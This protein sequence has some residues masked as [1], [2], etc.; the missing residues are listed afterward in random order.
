MKKAVL[1]LLVLILA[2]LPSVSAE[3][4]LDK[5]SSS[6]YNLGDSVY[7]SGYVTQPKEVMANLNTMLTCSGK[8]EQIDAQILDLNANEKKL[9]SRYSIIP[10]S[11]LGNCTVEISLLDGEAVLE[12]KTFSGFELINTIGGKFDSPKN[13]FQLGETLAINGLFSKVDKGVIDGAAVITFNKENKK[14]FIDTSEVTKGNLK[15]SRDLSRIP[16]GNYTIDISITDNWGNRGD[17]KG[18]LKLIITSKVEISAN[19][20]KNSYNPGEKLTITGYVTSASGEKLKDVSMKFKFED[21]EV[22]KKLTGTD[23]FNVNY[24]IPANVKSGVHKVEITAKDSQGNYGFKSVEFKVN[25]VA[26]FLDFEMNN[27][28]YEP[29]QDAEFKIKLLDQANEVMEESVNVNLLNPKGE[30]AS[31][32]TVKAGAADTIK[33]PD[34]AEPGVWKLSASGFGLTKETS[35]VVKEYTKL[36]ASIKEDSLIVKNQGNIPFKGDFQ[37]NGD[38]VSKSKELNIDVGKEK[39]VDLSKL[40]PEGSY[41]ISTPQTDQVFDNVLIDRKS[42]FGGLDSM[43]SGA[44]TSLNN[45]KKRGILFILAIIIL[46]CVF[47]IFVARKRKKSSNQPYGSNS[48]LSFGSGNKEQ[49][50]VRNIRRDKPSEYGRPAEYGK[51]TQEDVDYWKAK[52]QKDI[53]EQ[54]RSKTTNDFLRQQESNI[55]EDK[56][57]PGLF[58]MFR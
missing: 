45:T 42:L 24:N 51:A 21:N 32:K 50:R 13:S 22:N 29:S 1:F 28:N 44:T 56:P 38:N 15:Y 58:N 48:N 19:L 8:T 17:F 11:L 5:F 30:V 25:A 52:I 7:F 43:T 41:Q 6:K 2:L 18:A 9:F 27:T 57:K 20:D 34:K 40:F 53:Q 16:S 46:C 49:I 14:L 33:I 39:D 36:E 10:S 12:K 3:I 26:K 4:S 35:I 54:E 55:N 37:I 23:P 31:T 47:Y